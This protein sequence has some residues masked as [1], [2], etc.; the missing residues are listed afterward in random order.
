MA[1]I[2]VAVFTCRFPRGVPEFVSYK[3][4]WAAEFRQVYNFKLIMAHIS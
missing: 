3:S 2:F 1:E 4:T